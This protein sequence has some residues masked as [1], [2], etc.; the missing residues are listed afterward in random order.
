MDQGL[1]G[2]LCWSVLSVQS[3]GLFLQHHLHPEGVTASFI[4]WHKMSV[5]TFYF[6][7]FCCILHRCIVSGELQVFL[8]ARFALES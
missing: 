2:A 7:F 4:C 8:A 6:L 1:H 3:A 5:V